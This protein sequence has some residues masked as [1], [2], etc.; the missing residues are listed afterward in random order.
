MTASLLQL[1]AKG[2]EDYM[3]NGNPQI[4]FF[5]SVHLKYINFSIERLETLPKTKGKFSLTNT[6]ET[7]F[8]I[9]TDNMDAL[10]NIYLSITLPEINAKSPY[11][12]EW[13][14]NIGDFILEKA[15][16]I[17]NDIVI[18]S[19][20]S[21]I[22]HMHSKNIQNH[23]NKSNIDKIK[24][25]KLTDLTPNYTFNDSNEYLKEPNM[26]SINKINLNYNKIPS[27]PSEKIYIKLPFFFSKN[28]IK[29]PLV[30][31]KKNRLYIR[32]YLRPLNELFRISSPKKVTV[33]NN[34]QLLFDHTNKSTYN[35]YLYNIYETVYSNNNSNFELS[36]YVDN[37]DFIYNNTNASIISY[38]YFFDKKDVDFFK[39]K[40]EI[41][42]NTT[43]I[44]KNKTTTI[45]N[46][47]IIKTSSLIKEIIIVPS[48][49]DIKSRN[50]YNYY[51]IHDNKLKP[52][53][54]K[55]WYNYYFEL[56]YNQYISDLKYITSIN[57][58]NKSK[59]DK[60]FHSMNDINKP[61]Y[62]V[63]NYHDNKGKQKCIKY[64]QDELDIKN[65]YKYCSSYSDEYH[66]AFLYYGMFQNNTFDVTVLR[67]FFF[68]Y[69]LLNMNHLEQTINSL[70]YLPTIYTNS[71]TVYLYFDTPIF[72]DSILHESIRIEK[73]YNISKTD[74]LAILNNWNYRHFK[75]IPLITDDNYNYF[76]NDE[77][78]ESIN[79]TYKGNPII[80]KLDSKT[81]YKTI[82]FNHYRHNHNIDNIVK[83]PFSLKPNQYSPSGHLNMQ[84]LDKLD[85]FVKIKDIF[86]ND[87]LLDD[88]SINLDVYLSVINKIIIADDKIKML[89]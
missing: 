61:Y 72:T 46:E 7:V 9:N 11:K 87:P 47:L 12:F 64:R 39:E 8:E 26:N 2:N 84:E 63:F 45:N 80:N 36:N 68:R 22:I 30:S 23:N 13:I 18:E 56:S 31:L 40:T 60:V 10:G 27:I 74:I 89:I 57:N 6:S 24:S 54:V 15:D 85:I 44:F 88:N 43:E 35:E 21:N 32:L 17:I 65:L 76:N 67:P 70:M 25:I 19:I 28:E 1:V 38:I 75:K 5:K 58:L 37:I 59:I 42:V 62:V 20:D 48:R 79:I 41:L 71:D 78:I 33:R 51:G 3:I 4:S 53:S 69:K 52:A 77:C 73:K 49:N 66:S 14:D 83:I 86:V 55:R 34:S 82:Q 50:N 16:F 81:M 29:L